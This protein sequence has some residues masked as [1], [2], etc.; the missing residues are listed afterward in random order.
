M[1]GLLDTEGRGRDL[2]S[3]PDCHN[4]RSRRRCC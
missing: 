4:C 2:D 1:S 3:T